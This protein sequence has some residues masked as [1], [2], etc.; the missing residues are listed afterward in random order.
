MLNASDATTSILS[1]LL[2]PKQKTAEPEVIDEPITIKP[3]F[4]PVSTICPGD[5][6]L[7]R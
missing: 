2:K 4:N 5:K 7:T 1:V 6:L 3:E